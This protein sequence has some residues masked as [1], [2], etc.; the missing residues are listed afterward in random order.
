M[1]GKL[2]VLTMIVALVATSCAPAATPTPQVITKVETKIVEKVVKE[3][4]QVVV[5]PTAAAKPAAPT[6][7]AIKVMVVLPLTGLYTYPM[8]LGCKACL[9]A[10]EETNAAGG[11][12]GR[13]VF[14]RCMDDG[15]KPQLAVTLAH[16]L[17]DDP[18]IVAVYGT[19]E[20]ATQ[21]PMGP[22]FDKCRMPNVPHAFSTLIL[23]GSNVFQATPNCV[24]FGIA[25]AD[26]INKLA[27]AKSA[28]MIW[29]QDPCSE[30]YAKGFRDR[31][32]ELGIKITNDFPLTEG[33]VDFKPLLT[34]IKAANPDVVFGATSLP[35]AMIVKQMRE[36][37]IKAQ[38]AATELVEDSKEFINN[39]GQAAVGSLST[40]EVPPTDKDPAMLSFAK[41]FQDKWGV[42]PEPTVYVHYQNYLLLLD[43]IQRAGS[44]DRE[45]IIKALRETNYKGLV[46]DVSFNADGTAKS[47]PVFIYR[48][49]SDLTFT[50]E[51]WQWN[52]AAG[53]FSPF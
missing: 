31:C 52:R 50:K 2:L 8:D 40:G 17:C 12:L 42:P 41:R 39:A 25:M 15:T 21:V 23:G 3:T 24:H 10:A 16:E 7:A 4:Q 6:G 29:E 51:V 33:T 20:S 36:M 26:A 53:D 37:G 19:S 35:K 28:A 27:G 34:Q 18:S 30:Q 49:Q 38:Y 11:I 1:K 22:I 48:L 46:Y 13:P 45:A 9:M 44:T 47:P 43:A 32:K 14:T 5:T